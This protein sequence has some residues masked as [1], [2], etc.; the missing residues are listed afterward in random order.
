MRKSKK[1]LIGAVSLIVL[2]VI[3]WFAYYLIHYYFYNE[4]REDLSSYAYEEG[5]EFTPISEASS[6]VKGM[7]LAQENDNLK[8]YVNTESG[9]IALVDKRTGEITYSN[10]VDADADG[11]ANET[12][13]NYMKSQIVLDYFNTSRIQGTYDSYSYCTAKEGQLE[14]EAI[15]GG[16]RFLY[17]IGDLTSAT[18]IVPQYI[19]QE[20]L[21]Q[22][23]AALPE[24][25][26]KFVG[27]KFVESDVAEGY[28]E[29][30]ESTAKGASQLRK[31]NKY[32]EEAGFTLEDYSREMEN[33]GVEGVVPISFLIPLEYRLTEEALD[34]SVPMS[35]VQENGGGSIFR[36]SL[37]RYFGS[38]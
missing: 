5:Y 37:L 33:S 27:K 9:E 14:I 18:G 38:A 4:Y 34:V 35:G 20:T 6:D 8:L 15:E 30:L 1:I 23:M 11:I 31:L 7:V 21:N 25:E 16:V 19:S 3:I 22:V 28:L 13:K 2:G 32:F 26:A 24:K 29:M 10:P 17:T 12:N 36:I